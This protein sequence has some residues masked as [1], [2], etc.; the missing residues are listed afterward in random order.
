M[1]LTPV[2]EHFLSANLHLRLKPFFFIFQIE[3]FRVCGI[4]GQ[5]QTVLSLYS[6]LTPGIRFKLNICAFEA[7][8]KKC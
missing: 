1:A 8:H 7:V 3:Y 6:F 2:A 5:E 4:V